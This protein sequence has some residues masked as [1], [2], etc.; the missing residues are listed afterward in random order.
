VSVLLVAF[1]SWLGG[2]A[3]GPSAG[4]SPGSPSP[5]TSAAAASAASAA[6]PASPAAAPIPVVAAENFYGDLASQIGGRHV[7]V[8][9][10]LSDPST[11]PHTY[12]SNVEN[13][14]AIGAARLV[15]KNGLGYDGFMEKLLASSPRQD[16]VVIDV[17]QLLG[18]KKGENPHVWYDP[19]TMPKVAQAVADRLGQMDP[20]DKAEFDSRLREFNNS[21][22]PLQDQIAAIK[23][24]HAGAKVLPIEP[25]FDYMAEALGLE[26]VDKE[27]TFQRAVE[28]GN[29]PPAEA[30]AKFR[31]QLGSHSIKALIYN[32]QTVT[33]MTA[34]M[35]ATAKQ[36]NVPVVGVSETEP[37]GKT[38]QQWMVEQLLALQ[39]AL[40]S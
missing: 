24:K 13:A 7:S 34:Q 20:A 17:A 3:S 35:Q 30:V 37:P 15:I 14:K 28:E 21:L 39:Q 19:K 25:V 2:C 11:D 26:V 12:E 8:T 27:G 22:K 23:S 32:S 10:I 6:S 5:T 33:P 16:R 31:Q 18:T 38:Y 9:S 40:G 1:G 4:G 36:N 29:D